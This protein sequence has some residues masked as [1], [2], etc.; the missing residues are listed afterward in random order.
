MIL[1]TFLSL[2]ADH[3]WQSTA[4]AFAAALVA[5][6]AKKNPARVRYWIWWIASV[7]FL[8]PFSLLVTV[9]GQLSRGL[10]T[11]EAATPPMPVVL[12]Q[13]AQPFTS[14]MAWTIAS[15]ST[16]APVEKSTAT[17][18][19]VAVVLWLTGSVLMLLRWGRGW[20]RIRRL[21][22]KSR[23]ASFLIQS[24]ELQVLRRL[25]TRACLRRSLDM[26]SSEAVMEPCVFGL[27]RPTLIWPT[28]LSQRLTDDE[29]EGI[30]L[31]ELAHDRRRDNLTSAVH[32]LVEAFFWFHP[33][34]WWVGKRLLEERETACDED[35]LHLGGAPHAYAEGIL[36]VCEFCLATPLTC[37]A[38][39]TGADLKRR[40][41]GVLENSAVLQLS[42]KRTA[43]LVFTATAIVV[44]PVLLGFTQTPL[45][46]TFE[47]VSVRVNAG[48][49]GGRGLPIDPR[50]DFLAPSE[51]RGN[52]QLN[53][54]RLVVT[55]GPLYRLVALA[56]GKNCRLTIEQNLISG[57]PDW[58]KPLA[59]DI[60]ATIPEGTPAYTAQQLFNG[61]APILQKM[62]QNFL[63][64]RFKL[65]L[66]HNTK[67]IPVYNLVV[68]KMDKFRLSEDQ[69]PLSP[70]PPG[71]ARPPDPSAPPPRG[72]FGV[73]VDPPAGKVMIRANAAPISTIIN[74]IQGNV[75]RMVVDKT[76]LGLID[77]PAQTLDVGPYEISPT[78][79][80]VWPDIMQQ[81]G[82]RMVPARGPA[83]VLVIDHAEKPLEN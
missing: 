78:A 75:G 60:Q 3:L 31:H 38:G 5:L 81:L 80:T 32:M 82:L 76:G 65:V 40:I 9:G 7:K 68:V 63:A 47:V 34:V 57:G 14:N 30:L 26:V 37:A 24:R 51:C 59:F 22:A 1:T 83:E 41:E 35:V 73:G 28:G 70:P 20:R 49:P 44:S 48:G 46:E 77:I 6:T 74:F 55:A 66:G 58:T 4:F 27:L 10:G 45:R 56:Y 25:E 69:T 64:D 43:L 15:S 67:E 52:I 53:P 36:K 42:W 18:P 11:A 54:G 72:S 61:E 62:I 19:A 33:L 16:A 17:F 21:T 8:V 13:I 23:N 50:Y 79:Q 2:L 71:D 39:V 29:I 12:N